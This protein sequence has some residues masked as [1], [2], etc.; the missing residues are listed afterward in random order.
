MHEN[1]RAPGADLRPVEVDTSDAREPVSQER[2]RR[3]HPCKLLGNHRLQGTF[4]MLAASDDKPMSSRSRRTAGTYMNADALLLPVVTL[5][6]AIACC[7]KT[8]AL[9]G[10]SSACKARVR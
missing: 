9:A 2:S 10:N 5:R 7:T 1:E 8:R 6:G 3:T 4:A